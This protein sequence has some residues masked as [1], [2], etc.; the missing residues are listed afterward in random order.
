MHSVMVL[1]LPLRRVVCRRHDTNVTCAGNGGS[2]IEWKRQWRGVGGVG[3]HWLQRRRWCW[4]Q[5]RRRWCWLQRK[6][7]MDRKEV[8]PAAVR[9]TWN[10]Q[11]AGDDILSV[12]D[13]LNKLL[14]QGKTSHLCCAELGVTLLGCE[15]S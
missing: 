5:Q 14:E 7:T 1:L 15:A 6:R 2:K 9:A 4:L 11:R 3:H 12:C 13:N 10:R 8:N